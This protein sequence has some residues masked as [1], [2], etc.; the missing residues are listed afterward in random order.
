[1][2]KFLVLVCLISFSNVF[3][4]KKGKK[5]DCPT[6][7]EDIRQ[8]LVFKD[9][10]NLK[11]QNNTQIET[12]TKL[13]IKDDSAG[14][15]SVDKVLKTYYSNKSK[16][17]GWRIQIWDGTNHVELNQEM[18]KYKSL[19]SSLGLPVHDEYDKTMFRLRIGDFTNRLEAYKMLQKIKKEFPNALLVPDEVDLSKN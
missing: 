8:T 1:M 13:S 2:K 6:Y 5:G 9:K 12:K 16:A 14:V 18:A 4:Q 11:T 7:T 17:K 3:A 10:P 19:F 15:D